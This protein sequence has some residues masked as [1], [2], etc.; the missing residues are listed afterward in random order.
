MNQW[1]EFASA[2][3]RNLTGKDATRLFQGCA[4]EAPRHLDER[5]DWN[6]ENAELDGM[7]PD[8]T[9]TVSDHEVNEHQISKCICGLSANGVSSV[10]GC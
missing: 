1:N 2:I 6:V 9:K 10:Y 4:F 3:S 8:K 5:T 7:G